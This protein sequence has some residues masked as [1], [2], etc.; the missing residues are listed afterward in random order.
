MSLRHCLRSLKPSTVVRRTETRATSSAFELS[1]PVVLEHLATDP[2]L[3]THRGDREIDPILRG[4]VKYFAIGHS[5]RCFSYIR[6]WGEK[7]RGEF[8]R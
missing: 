6:D 4:W 1:R 7:K 8:S 3:T 2:V 5:S